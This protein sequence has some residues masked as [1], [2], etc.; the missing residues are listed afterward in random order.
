MTMSL[1]RL[2]IYAYRDYRF[3]S[4]FVYLRGERTV[5]G[6]VIE[7]WASGAVRMISKS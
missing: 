6:L 7:Y 4:R 3:C 1:L 5:I 2:G